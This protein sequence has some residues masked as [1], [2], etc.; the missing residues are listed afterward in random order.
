[1]MAGLEAVLQVRAAHLSQDG[2]ADAHYEHRPRGPAVGRHRLKPL[3][4]T[5]ERSD[6]RAP[7]SRLI[8]RQEIVS[9]EKY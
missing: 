8:D 1:M 3:Q 4:P 9:S 2:R 7:A 6:G 5:D